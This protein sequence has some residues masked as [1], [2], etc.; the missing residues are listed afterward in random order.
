MGGEEGEGD[1]EGDEE[2][3][4]APRQT[5]IPSVACSTPT[6]NGPAAA[7]AVAG[8]PP[9]LE[10]PGEVPATGAAAAAAAAP[11]EVLAGKK[12]EQARI[13]VGGCAGSATEAGEEGRV[14]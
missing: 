11:A 3:P 1:E 13:G 8:L 10:Q 4:A 5:P 2:G 6:G 7:D 9:A 14:S 12:V